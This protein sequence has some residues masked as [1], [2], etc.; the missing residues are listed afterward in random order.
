MKILIAV[1]CM[2][3]VPVEFCQSLALL[4][5]VGDCKLA[6]N[7]GSL[8]YTSREQLAKMAITKEYDYVL[9]LDSDMT[10]NPDTLERLLKDAEGRDFVSGVYYRRVAPYTPVLFNKLEMTEDGSMDWTGYDEGIPEGI[11]EIGGC[12]FGCCLTSVDML[13][14]M[15]SNF[16][17]LFQPIGNNGEDV[18]FCIRAK[19]MGYHLWC[20]SSI[21]CGHI[22]KLLSS[23]VLFKAL[24]K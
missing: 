7:S 11:F 22:G 24:K 15:M 5:K 8:V 4:N 20:D 16:R 9:W 1:P 10:F 17:T 13:F 3:Y 6:M 2:D 18:A 12:G 21:Q 14:D 23:E 19:Q